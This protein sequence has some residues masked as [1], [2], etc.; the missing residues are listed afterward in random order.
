MLV[1]CPTHLWLGMDRNIVN[2]LRG[3]EISPNGQ[4]T[5]RKFHSWVE[6][7][8]LE[9]L[10]SQYYPPLRVQPEPFP[11]SALAF[12][13]AGNM[14]AF[15]H[16]NLVKIITWQTGRYLLQPVG[17][18][19]TTWAVKFHP[20]ESNVFTSGIRRNGVKVWN[21]NHF[22][23]IRIYHFRTEVLSVAFNTEE[24]LAV[25]SENKLFIWP[26]RAGEGEGPVDLVVLEPILTI[27]SSIRAVYFHPTAAYLMTAEASEFDI[28][29]MDLATVP[30]D[31]HNLSVSTG[32]AFLQVQHYTTNLRIWEYDIRNP[33]TALTERRCR[34]TIQQVILCREMGAHI[35]PCGRFLA[36]CVAC[37][38]PIED[39][40]RRGPRRVLFELRIYSLME[41]G[42]I[43]G[44]SL[45]SCLIYAPAYVTAIQVY[46]VRNLQRIKSIYSE[47][48]VAAAACFH[49]LAGEGFA[50]GT[51]DGRV[52]F[53]KSDI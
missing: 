28:L 30:R 34:L 11:I 35:S 26:Y 2:L 49:P 51:S 12:N 33:Y 38:K 46:S 48:E 5:K 42:P 7:R 17:E 37:L 23:V 19:V 21:A 44:F 29:A 32:A 6:A 13:Q 22:A 31:E 53:L 45:R 14:L 24:I 25:A 16:G 20:I 41:P 4:R 3:R 10:F 39:P 8:S 18:N 40:P 47:Q 1:P 36:V 52:R 15:N 50:Y 43:F 9:H 27:R